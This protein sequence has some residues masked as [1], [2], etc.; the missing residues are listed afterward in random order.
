MVNEKYGLTYLMF[1]SK[2]FKNKCSFNKNFPFSFFKI[3]EIIVLF[4]DLTRADVPLSLSL[5]QRIGPIGKL[6]ESVFRC[7]KLWFGDLCQNDHCSNFEKSFWKHSWLTFLILKL[8]PVALTA[9][10]AVDAKI[11]VSPGNFVYFENIWKW[12][13]RNDA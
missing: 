11:G 8:L 12:I 1:F 13:F 2:T 10:L 3:I 9:L 5:P 4:I 7:Q 6:F